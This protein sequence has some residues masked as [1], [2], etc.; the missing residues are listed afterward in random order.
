[1]A[2]R[3]CTFQPAGTYAVWQTLKDASGTTK[4]VNS[5]LK[6]SWKK[7][8]WSTKAI[9][10]SFAQRSCLTTG[11][12]GWSFLVQSATSYGT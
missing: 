4:V 3:F 11:N 9:T 1:M 12:A 6:L 8:V 7:L 10:K 2:G 5:T